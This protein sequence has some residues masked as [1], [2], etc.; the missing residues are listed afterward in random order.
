MTK[1]IPD[2]YPRVTPYLIVD[3]GGAAIDFYS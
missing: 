2:N 1:P 3:D